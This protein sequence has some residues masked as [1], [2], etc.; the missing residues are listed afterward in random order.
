MTF[1]EGWFFWPHTV[2]TRY[3]RRG[4]TANRW[5]RRIY[6]HQCAMAARLL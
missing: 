6:L 2:G 4:V 1:N 5:A 3:K